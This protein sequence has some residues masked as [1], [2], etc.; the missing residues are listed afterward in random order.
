MGIYH[1]WILQTAFQGIGIL[2]VG[3]ADSDRVQH[4]CSTIG[5][6][7]LQSSGTLIRIVIPMA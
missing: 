7:K 5:A 2:S 3:N 4:C 1:G 6:K